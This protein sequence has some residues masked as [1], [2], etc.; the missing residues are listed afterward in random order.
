MSVFNRPYYATS[1]AG[2]DQSG[3]PRFCRSARVSRTDECGIQ[4]SFSTGSDMF[5]RHQPKFSLASSLPPESPAGV[6]RFIQTRP[7][8]LPI[9]VRFQ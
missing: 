2:A 5:I 7:A 4:L 1:V 3:N 8:H 9:S 6:F